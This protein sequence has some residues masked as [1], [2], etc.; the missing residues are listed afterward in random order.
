MDSLSIRIS[1]L[2][3]EGILQVSKW[4]KVQILLDTDEMEALLKILEPVFFV[5]VSEP[6]KAD[7]TVITP[8]TFLSKYADYIDLLKQGQVPPAGEFRR[9]FSS[10]IS[11]SLETFYAIPVSND[12][13]LIKPSKPVLQLQAHHFFYSDLDGKFH[14]MVLSA[15]SISWGLQIS[16]PQLYQDPITRQVSKVIDSPIFPNTAVFTKLLKWMR[17]HTLP[18]P[19][20]VKGARINSPIRVGKKSLAWLKNHPQLKQKGIDL[21]FGFVST[22]QS[23]DY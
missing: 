7:E 18:T 19:F 2:K 3:T 9:F 21:S 13:F 1:S 6:V 20:Q 23:H 10:A 16:Y 11:S 8:G 14:P 15:D 5:V 17:S 12:K 4:L 22:R